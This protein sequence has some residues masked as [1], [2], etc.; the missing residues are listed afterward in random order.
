MSFKITPTVPLNYLFLNN[1][2]YI[3]IWLFECR[4]YNSHIYWS[5]CT[6]YPIVHLFIV[7]TKQKF[8]TQGLQQFQVILRIKRPWPDTNFTFEEKRIM[9]KSLNSYFLPKYNC[10]Q[11]MRPVQEQQAAMGWGLMLRLGWERGTS[12]ADITG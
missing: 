11:V 7:K 2:T 6:G 10:C 9:G 4:L 5:D 8:A 1:A 12:A 3:H